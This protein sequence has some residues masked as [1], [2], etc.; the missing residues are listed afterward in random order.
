MRIH[1][2]VFF[3]LLFYLFLLSVF[4]SENQQLKSALS[5]LIPLAGEVRDW[6]PDGKA[7]Y[8]SGQDLYL[9]INGG[10]EIYF[11]YGFKEAAYQSYKNKSG[12][13]IN[14][15]IYEMTD[16]GAAYGIYTFKT[17]ADGVPIDCGQGGW[18]ESYFLNF[19]E[20]NFL[21]TLT[22]LSMEG[23]ALNGIKN[24]AFAVD[25]KL[26]SESEIPPLIKFLPTEDLKR[27]GITY[28]RGNLALF[29]Q[30]IFDPMDIFG[31][32]EGVIG[33][34]GDYSILIF[35]YQDNEE[36]KKWY[37][38]SKTHLQTSNRFQNL[39]DQ[40]T[41]FEVSNNQNKKLTVKCFQR[42]ILAFLG[43]EQAKRDQIFETLSLKFPNYQR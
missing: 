40:G 3:S 36:S 25:S 34:Y 10:A 24:I 43:N 8:A 28:M 1:F 15:E 12:Q 17:G 39:M 19:W 26:A 31:L 9:V 18:L 4:G 23:Q 42:W 29:N 13:S 6:Y 37:E 5:K 30:D 33:R 41:Q 20:G 7:E 2:S 14:L 22:A 32:K 38:F 27:N 35:Q 16:P 11:E 21:I